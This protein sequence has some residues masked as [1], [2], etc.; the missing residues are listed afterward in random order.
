MKKTFYLFN[1]GTLERRDNTLKFTPYTMNE[2]G[3][4][5]TGNPRYLPVEDVGEF[6]AFGSLN[7]NSAVLNFLGQKDIAVHFFDYYEN[8]TGS[9]MPRDALLSGKLLLAQVSAYQNKK[10]RQV[11]ACKFIE[12]AVYNMIKNL[13]YY[14][15]RG[16]DMEVIIEAIKGYSGKIHSTGS[17]EELMGIEGSIRQLYYEA[18]GKIINDFEMGSRTKQPPENEVN[19]LISFG[20]MMCY[21]F[22]LRAIHQTQ[23]NPTIS[24][25]HAPGERRY[26]L[27]LDVSEIFKPIL[28]DRVIF[29]VL[30]KREIQSEHFDH[31][32]NKCLL[33]DRGKQIFVKAMEARLSDTIQHR[34]LGRNVS[35]KHLVKLECYKLA[36]H[37][38]EIEDYKPFKMYW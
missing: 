2:A 25:L 20:N 18:F 4:R 28:V 22:C 27:S 30:N 9:F 3:E 5:L 23:L 8:Y 15:R 29:K 1:P 6:Y 31:K 12:G 19:A 35:Y 13:Q 34:S 7:V 10:K 38:L 14:N 21:S 33:N 32:M 17:V 26:S 24:Y 11:I 36:K 37:L 16:K